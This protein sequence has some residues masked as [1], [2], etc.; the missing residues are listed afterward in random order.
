MKTYMQA[1]WILA[2]GI[3]GYMIG[4]AVFSTPTERAETACHQSCGYH[5]VASFSSDS[6][7]NVT[8]TCR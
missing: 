7:G 8:C 2:F 4:E 1:V 6:S 5:G 3:A